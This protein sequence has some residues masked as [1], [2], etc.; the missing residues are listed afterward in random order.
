M[1]DGIARPQVEGLYPKIMFDNIYKKVEQWV[2]MYVHHIF[3]LRNS[4]ESYFYELN[5]L[6]TN[7]QDFVLKRKTFA[8]F[9]KFIYK[10][11]DFEAHH[12]DIRICQSYDLG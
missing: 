3:F 4:T 10:C 12:Q 11:P 7:F 5:I 6:F 2:Y 1:L 8:C 9:Y